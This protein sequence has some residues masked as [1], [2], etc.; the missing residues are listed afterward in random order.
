[1]LARSGPQE[2]NSRA[3]ATWSV[4]L[5]RV[6]GLWMLCA[7]SG[8][9]A[10]ACAPV[11]M[12]AFMH[13]WAHVTTATPGA[14]AH[15]AGSVARGPWEPLAARVFAGLCVAAVI[16]WLLLP[17]G[18]LALLRRNHPPG[19]PRWLAPLAQAARRP[20]FGAQLAVQMA[21]STLVQAL[22]ALALACGALALGVQ[23][24]L[25]AWAF[26][27]AP[28]FLM[29]TLPVSIGGWGTREAAAAVALAPFGIPAAAAVGAGLLYGVFMLAQG[30]LGALAFG[31][32]KRGDKVAP[33]KPG[34]DIAL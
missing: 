9:G 16:I 5:D 28:I 20:D 18:L 1:M 7:I 22:S 23:L 31:L 15:L 3:T 12:P 13:A 24:P 30:A 33:N 2:N 10:A 26:A 11:L 4:A 17:W 25:A 19:L 34:A 32:P 27:I 14:L 8:L 29:A 6:S 21:A